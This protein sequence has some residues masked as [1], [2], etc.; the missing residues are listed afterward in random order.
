LRAAN[1]A[2]ENQVRKMK[3]WV[4]GNLAEA[5]AKGGPK[6]AV[7]AA[8]NEGDRFFYAGGALKK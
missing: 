8:V 4:Y 7:G 3:E 1:H 5:I 6:V 2:K